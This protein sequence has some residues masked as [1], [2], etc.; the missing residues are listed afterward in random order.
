MALSIVN[1]NIAENI[2]WYARLADTGTGVS[3]ELYLSQ[4]NAEAQTNLQASGESSGY[5]GSQE[6]TLTNEPEAS[7]P[8]SLFQESYGWHLVVSGEIGDPA[9]I[10]KIK[11][12]V[13]LD[14]IAHAVYRNSALV[15]ARAAA[16]INAHTHARITREIGLGVH[17]PQLDPGD[18]VR[19]NS[20]RRNVDDLGQ[21]FEH[22]ITGTPDSLTS[23]VEAVRF[24][25]LK[26]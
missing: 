8:V 6:I 18:T 26:R 17:L 4:A 21:V 16:E 14:E 12:F 7:T 5:G 2:V 13:D 11:Q 9:K 19:M 23:E 3:V 24:L 10:F 25:E 1:W 15:E 20:T 22:R